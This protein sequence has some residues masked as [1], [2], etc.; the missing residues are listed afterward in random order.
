[1]NALEFLFARLLQ[2]CRKQVGLLRFAVYNSTKRSEK[3]D[4]G[5]NM[6]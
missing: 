5:V 2:L 3:M 1:M 6:H 4:L